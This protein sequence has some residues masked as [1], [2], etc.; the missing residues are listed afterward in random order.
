MRPPAA[1]ALAVTIIGFAAIANAQTGWTGTVTNISTPVVTGGFLSRPILAVEPNGNAYAIWNRV[2]GTP[3]NTLI[4]ASRYVAATD[5]WSTPMTLAG[6][7][8]FGPPEVAVDGSGNAFFLMIRSLASP[9]QI[10]LVRYVPTSGAMTTATLSSNV[11]PNTVADVVA[12]AAGNAIAVW[13]ET[14]GIYSARYDRASAAWSTPVK[15]SAAGANIP[16]LAIDGLNDVTA[17]WRWLSPGGQLIFQAARF[18][19][20][21][22]TW[23]PVSDLSA[24]SP[25]VS[26]FLSIRIAADPAGNVTAVWSRSN[27]TFTIIQAARFVKAAGS[28]TSATDLSVPGANAES[29][30]VAADPAGNVIAVWRRAVGTTFIIQTARFDVGS[31][32]W[33]SAEDLTSPAGFAYPIPQVR[34]DASGNGIAIWGRSEPGLGLQIQAARYTAASNQWS[35]PVALSAAGE[36]AYNPDIRFDAA[37]NGLAAWFQAAGS[38]G[39]VQTTRWIDQPPAA[40]TDLVVTSVTDNTVS[41]A[42]KPGV[43]GTPTGY[44]L[45]GGLSPGGVLASLRTG[46]TA[47]TFT[48]NAPSGVFFVRL[49]ALLGN[50]RSD[51]SNEIRLVVNAPLAPSAPG[52]VLGL[53][54][55]STLSLSWTNTFT[56]GAPTALQLN[57]TGGQT[58][59]VPFGV[60][61]KVTFN[62]VPGGTYTFTLTAS[63]AAGISPPSAPVTLTFPGG[64]TGPPGVP[65]YFAV[66]KAGSLLTLTWNPPVAGAAVTHYVIHASGTFA[67]SVPTFTRSLT[68]SVGPGTYSLSVVAANPC[69]TSAPSD[70]VTVNVP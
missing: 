13:E 64:C 1:A 46:S 31:A 22:L 69:G 53:V 25:T 33:S 56:G 24:P 67:G 40:P 21:T 45:E 36:G 10:Q 23:G 11:V 35:A 68:G 8:P 38:F 3:G 42:W 43:G 28:W 2:A 49:H 17:A 6:P 55:G 18:D 70:V 14:A 29:T 61:D 37:G 66:A 50:L 16:R 41:L 34:L 15:I 5:S 12:D 19:S 62:V 44:V 32:S 51:A 57:V 4:Q 59:S 20:S 65:T 52:N 27:G 9:A 63:N 48:F 47:T 7:A 39:V 54:N 30:G 58:G 26:V 60:L